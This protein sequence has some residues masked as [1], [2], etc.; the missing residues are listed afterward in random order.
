[1]LTA[2]LKPYTRLDE[3]L[4]NYIL[5]KLPGILAEGILERNI[6]ILS[7]KTG[8]VVQNVV[9]KMNYTTC[10]GWYIDS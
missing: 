6:I 2:I 7:P 8:S 9:P 10:V 4:C 3:I 5:A 1:M